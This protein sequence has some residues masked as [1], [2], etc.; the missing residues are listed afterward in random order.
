MIGNVC[1]MQAWV[2]CYV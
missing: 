1:V 2:R